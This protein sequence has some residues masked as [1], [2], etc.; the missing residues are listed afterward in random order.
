MDGVRDDNN[1]KPYDASSDAL[2]NSISE[3]MPGVNGENVDPVAQLAR[4]TVEARYAAEDGV[5]VDGI[6]A[7]GRAIYQDQAVDVVDIDTAGGGKVLVKLADGRSVD[8]TALEYEDSGEAELWRVIGQYAENAEA[9]RV[10]LQEYRNGDLDAYKYARGIEEAFLFGKLNLSPK[11]MEIK[12]SMANLLSPSQ[13]QVAYEQGKRAGEKKTQQTKQQQNRIDAVYKQ[14]K[15]VLQQKGTDVGNHGVQLADGLT[16]EK[17]GKSQRASY[18]LAKMIAPGVKADTRIYNGGKEWGYYDHKTDTICLNINAK[19][20]GVSMMSFTMAHELVH[21]AAL[22]SQVKYQA[23]ADFLVQQYGEQGSS[24]N[25]MVQEQLQAAE[26]NDISMT[27]EEAFDEVICDACQRMLLD[28]DA[29]QRLAEFGAKSAQNKSIVKQFGQWVRELMQKLR[30]IFRNVEPDSL[31]AQEFQ[32]FDDNVKQIL[33]DM[34]V[35]MSVDAGEK[36]S[37]IKAA[38][39][40]EKI[41]TGVGGDQIAKLDADYLDAVNRGDTEAAQQMV[42]QA[43]S[44]AGAIL[45]ENGEPLK[46]YRGTYGGQTT[47]AKDDTYNGKIY[48][49]D[50]IDV[51]TKY[52]DKSGKATDIQHQ[53]K[54]E[55]TTYALYGFSQKTLTIDAKYGVWSD[56]VIP[57]ELLEYAD[58]RYKAT[59]AEIAEWAEQAGY[60]ALR[61][62]NVRD[63]SFDEGSEIIFFNEN[64]VKSADPV[65]YD[66]KG[67][68]IPLS[69]RFDSGKK[70][71]RYKL[72]VERKSPT[73]Q[74]LVNKDPIAIID[75]GRNDGGLSYADIKKQVLENANK[76]KVFDQPHLN[77]DTGVSI[78]LTPASYSHAFSNPT[79]EFGV[80]TLLAMNHITDIIHEAVLTHIDLPK[81]Q[82]RAEKRVFTFFAAIEGENGVEPIKLKVKEYSEQNPERLPKNIRK[83]FVDKGALETHNRLYDA[84]ALEVVAIEGA[85]KESGASAS[86]TDRTKRKVAKGTPNSTIKIA[87]LFDLV[88][89]DAKKYIP[90]DETG[91][92]YK[93]PAGKDA[94]DRGMLVDLFEQM[95]TDSN[96]YR[97]LQKYKKNIN[98]MLALEEKVDRL[99]EE[100]KRVSF[101]E[102][103]KNMEYLDNLKAQRKQAVAELNR[104]DNILLGLEKSG[105]LRAMIDRNR[106]MIQQETRDKTREYYRQKNEARE[107]EIRQ[108]YR[109][110]R[111]K[112]VER[113]DQAQVRQ[114]IRKD[115]QKLDSLLNKGTKEKNVKLELREFAGAAL[116]TAKEST[117]QTTGAFIM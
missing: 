26:E 91:K 109:E 69:E 40:T 64:A 66:D 52:G 88:N 14:A 36:L 114:R 15:S 95:V 13:R 48:T 107:A 51:A 76:N 77:R 9:A 117:G 92:Q 75:I 47:F 105:V 94:A 41:T 86:G 56:L 82:L 73:Y 31:A 44:E 84:V 61:I 72:P 50:N 111:R 60:D 102:D 96:E 21:R 80:D 25:D 83:Y 71:I 115:V 28:T 27:Y 74:E 8:A 2:N 3:S 59:N 112:A 68:V 97:E 46:L 79:A 100:I 42:D 29:G 106:Q 49:I 62:D 78:F 103:P 34:F 89:G 58:G 67:N 24:V 11:E 16:V 10:L 7:E 53:T 19:W 1:R 37:T 81:N 38:G 18:E 33:A 93:L 55:K 101:A 30:R 63:G 4:E 65:T 35:D 90:Q 110:S 45:D 99:T 54:G 6:S 57:E 23:F 116:R 87:E 39:M 104:F 70:D 20:D 98:Q 12:D 17:M 108:Y 43:A 32:K 22:G 5:G 113:H 85:K